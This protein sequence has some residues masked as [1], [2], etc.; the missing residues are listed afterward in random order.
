M[1]DTPV[2][3]SAL[4][5]GEDLVLQGIGVVADDAEL[6]VDAVRGGHSVC[7]MPVPYLKNGRSVLPFCGLV[8]CLLSEILENHHE[9]LQ[10]IT[11]LGGVRRA[12][13]LAELLDVGAVG[14]KLDR[15]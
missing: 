5:Y 2:I 15:V 4:A 3:V 14:V 12:N 11:A 9:E 10:E 7:G 13:V 8:Y 6:D 1:V